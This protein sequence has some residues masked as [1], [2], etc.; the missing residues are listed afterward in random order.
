MLLTAR[1][2]DSGD[3]K[4]H[5][6]YQELHGDKWKS[7]KHTRSSSNTR[8]KGRLLIPGFYV[9]GLYVESAPI[10]SCHNLVSNRKQLEAEQMRINH[11]ARGH[12]ERSCLPMFDKFLILTTE[13]PVKLLS[14]K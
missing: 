12:L 3:T 5:K 4:Q 2:Q 13:I 1:D 6:E 11:T 9:M 14:N 10:R 7:R 8:R